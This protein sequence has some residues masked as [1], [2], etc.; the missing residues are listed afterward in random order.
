MAAWMTAP[1]NPLVARVAVNRLWELVF[2]VG[3][4]YRSAEFNAFVQREIEQWAQVI[5]AAGI[6]PQ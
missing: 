1:D 2:G 5:K 4:G 3:L 6:K